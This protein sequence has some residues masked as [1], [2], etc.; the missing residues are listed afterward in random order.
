MNS[1]PGIAIKGRR[2]QHSYTTNLRT[3]FFE[4][5]GMPAQDGAEPILRHTVE[6]ILDEV[7]PQSVLLQRR[8]FQR[9]PCTMAQAPIE[10]QLLNLDYQDTRLKLGIEERT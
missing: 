2:P 9:F 7:F 4:H 1:P 8:Q 6:E 5:K 10:K 3:M